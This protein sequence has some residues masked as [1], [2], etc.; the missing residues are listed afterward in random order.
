M[1]GDLFTAVLR[2]CSC[3][4]M[5][6][7][8][9]LEAETFLAAMRELRFSDG[10]ERLVR[11]GYGSKRLV[12]SGIGPVTVQRVRLCDRGANAG[13]DNDTSTE[14]SGFTSANQADRRQ[15]GWPICS[16]GKRDCMVFDTEQRGLAVRVA[17][18][19][20]RSY[21]AQHMTAGRKRR[22]PLGGALTPQ[23]RWCLC[24]GAGGQLGALRHSAN[25]QGLGPPDRVC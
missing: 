20:S 16:P 3:H 25:F 22:V 8:I 12:Q 19:G 17:A 9:E 1:V 10:R 2:D 14:R 18:S 13:D 24:D 7:A 21:L 5:A 23:A 6:Q 15:T 4:L 11:H